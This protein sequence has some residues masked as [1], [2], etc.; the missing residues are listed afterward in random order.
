M[1]DHDTTDAST[2][3]PY[4]GDIAFDVGAPRDGAISARM[5]VTDGMRNPF[6]TVHAGALIWFADVT[7]T[8]LVLDGRTPTPGMTGFPLAINLTA[9]LVGNLSAGTLTATARFV[10]RGRTLSIVRTT[11]C[12]PDDRLLLDVTT[13][14]LA[15]K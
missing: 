5:T 12:G 10:K 14:H 9:N 3:H 15:A 8:H 2:S 4:R 1:T 11:V 7:A 6:G 13:T